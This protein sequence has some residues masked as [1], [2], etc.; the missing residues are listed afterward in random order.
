[1]LEKLRPRR[2][3]AALATVALTL[4]TIGVN[5]ATAHAGPNPEQLPEV[6]QKFENCPVQN[7]DVT[8]CYYIETSSAVMTAGSFSGISTTEPMILQFGGIADTQNQRTITVAPTNGVTAL[9]SPKLRLP[10]GLTHMPW[11]DGWPLSAYITP[12]NVGLPQLNLSNLTTSGDAP[13]LTMNIKARVHNPFTDVLS[14]LGDGCYIG[15][16]SSPIRLELTT[17]TTDPKPP[18]EP[19]SGTPGEFD[20]SDIGKGVIMIKGQTVVDNTWGL[21][22]ADGCGAIPYVGDSLNWAV[23]LDAGQANAGPGHNSVEMDTTVYQANADSVREAMG[24]AT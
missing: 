7:P 1:M 23:D 16:D 13:V 11:A 4:G 2:F 24:M 8:S 18:N 14:S 20:F 3:G 15:S 17:G 19:I 6:L 5:A 9:Q 10:G 21:P 22:H 12:E